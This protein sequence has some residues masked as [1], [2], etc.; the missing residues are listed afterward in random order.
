MHATVCPGAN[1]RVGGT[2]F[3]HSSV[4]SGQRGW[5]T[6]PLGGLSG[7][8]SSPLM[9]ERGRVRS[10]TGSGIGRGGQQRL[11]VGMLRIGEQ[12]VGRRIFDDAAE[13]HDRDLARD[14]P[15]DGQIVGDEQIGEAE[16]LL[17][18]LQQVDDLPLDRHVE[19][20]D[21][22]VAHDDARITASARAMPTRWRWP[23][24]SSWG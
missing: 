22:L 2:A 15:H 17:Q 23:P 6:Q 18:L 11:R 4:A 5:K 21:R 20:G 14:V 12:L 9:M 7:L 13:I 16:L 1:S 24:D 10:I 8:G 19:R 3:L